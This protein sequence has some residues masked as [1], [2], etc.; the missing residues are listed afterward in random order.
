MPAG[1]RLSV[2][3]EED[4]GRAGVD[5]A[6][7]ARQQSREARAQDPAVPRQ[8][9]RGLEQGRP[10]QPSAVSVGHRH[11]PEG[12]R[13]RRRCAR[14]GRRPDGSAAF[15]RGRRTS[16]N[17]RPSAPPRARRSWSSRRFGRR[18]GRRRRRRRSRRSAARRRSARAWSR[19][20]RRSRCRPCEGFR[21]PPRPLADRR[22]RPCL[23]RC[24]SR[25]EYR[26][27]PACGLPPGR[28]RGPGGGRRERGGTSR[29]SMAGD[30]SRMLPRRK[31]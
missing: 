25:P 20:R 15:R 27:A 2:R 5:E 29:F 12:S 17:P 18:C 24:G 9:D 28:R 8:P 31:G 6:R 10:G 1:E 22:P 3:I 11:R 21:R 19:S 30:T 26:R 4:L 16:A 14:R 7:I 13:E 23:A